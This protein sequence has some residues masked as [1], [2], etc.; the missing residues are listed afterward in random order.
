MAEATRLREGLQEVGDL[1]HRRAVGGVVA[2][3]GG[4]HGSQ[5]VVCGQRR[6][7]RVEDLLHGGDDVVSLDVVRHRAGDHAVDRDAEGPHVARGSGGGAP[8]DLGGEVGGRAGDE[9]GARERLVVLATGD[10]EVAELRD[11]VA[12][13]E[14]VRRLHVAVHEPVGVGRGERVG[15]LREEA[16]GPLE[17]EGAVVGEVGE[18]RPVDELHDE[19]REVAVV[20]EV[21]D[22]DD[23]RVVDPRRQPRLPLGACGVDLVGA[24]GEAQSLEG[25][26]T[27]ENG[28][29]ACPHAGGATSTDLALEPVPSWDHRRLLSTR[30]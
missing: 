13:D 18:R 8:G 5:R 29:V 19:P 27:V 4:N 9:A 20:G 24:G 1:A 6:R 2:G 25:H 3:R 28:V 15:H 10:A 14:D 21:V 11:V 7:R 30:R 22:G 16:G 17:V 26:P 12:G 23:V